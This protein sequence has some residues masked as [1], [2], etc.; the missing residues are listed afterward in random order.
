VDLAIYQVTQDSP[1]A[2]CYQVWGLYNSYGIFING[3][4][5]PR[6]AIQFAMAPFRSRL[7]DRRTIPTMTRFETRFDSQTTLTDAVDYPFTTPP[8]IYTGSPASSRF[9]NDASSTSLP[10][11]I[12]LRANEGFELEGQE[13][14]VQLTE[15]TEPSSTKKG[16]RFWLIYATIN[17]STLLVAIDL[18]IVSTALPTI[19]ADLDAKELFVWVGNA[20]VL[21]SSAVQPLFGQAAN[22]FGRRSLT[23][24]S[25]LLFI[26]GSA[27][28]GASTSITMMIAG[29]SVQG[30]G[31]GG[32]FL[33][34]ITKVM[35]IL[36]RYYYTR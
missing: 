24:L 21:S 9:F 4:G 12:S 35:L 36:C 15:K 23:I 31:G 32:R 25:I 8:K 26:L 3:D 20:Y 7:P 29:R 17:V 1:K 10:N 13:D 16:W 2:W 18:S 6:I 5:L 11:E 22:I 33:L 30:V 14:L 28:A 27:L 19:S 34:S